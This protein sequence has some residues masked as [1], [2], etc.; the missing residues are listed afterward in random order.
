MRKKWFGVAF[1]AVLLFMATSGVYGKEDS[2]D[3]ELFVV[4]DTVVAY[5]PLDNRPI[6]TTR[7]SLLAESI[8]YTIMVPDEDLYATHLDNQSLNENGTQY[9]DGEKLIAWIQQMDAQGCDLFIISLDQILYGGLVNSRV[10]TD[11]RTLPIDPSED[12]SPDG[13]GDGGE[14][15]ESGD[16]ENGNQEGDENEGH[17]T[18]PAVIFD[19]EALAQNIEELKARYDR[20]Y[21]VLTADP[22]NRIF[23][24]DTVMRLATTV[25]Y[26]GYDEEIYGIYRAYAGVP[27]KILSDEELTVENIIAG[28]PYGQDGELA[29]NSMTDSDD[30]RLEFLQ[31]HDS[32]MIQT[33]L[34][35]RER[36]LRLSD[37]V[38]SKENNGQIHYFIGVDDSISHDS[39]QTN[40]REY[41]TQKLEGQGT[42]FEGTDELGIMALARLYTEER[43]VSVPIYLKYYG[44]GQ[45][46]ISDAYHADSLSGVVEKHIESLN[47]TIM[48]TTYNA[49]VHFYVLTSPLDSTKKEKYVEELIQD[50]QRNI[51]AHI[52]TIIVD[53]SGSDYGSLFYGRLIEETE[54]GF[55]LGYSS[56]NTWGN[57]V[58]IGLSQGLCRYIYLTGNFNRSEEAD[59]A[60]VQSLTFSFIKDIAYQKKTKSSLDSYYSR[61]LGLNVNNFYANRTKPLPNVVQTLLEEKMAVAAEPILENLL[62]SNFITNFSPYAEKQVSN[63]DLSDYRFP[64]SR[65]FEMNFDIDVGELEEPAE[66]VIH[67]PY[68]SG[69]PDG[70]FQPER[71]TSREEVAKMIAIASESELL[72]YQGAYDDVDE[73][74]WSASY[75]ETVTDLGCFQGYGGGIF[76]PESSMTRAEFAAFMVQ[77][78][79]AEGIELESSDATFSDV[80]ESD[81]FASAVDKV[82]GSGLVQGYPDQT[83]RPQQYVTRAE[84]VTMLNRLLGRDPETEELQDPGIFDLC[85][86]S[87][88]ETDHWAYLDIMEA[89]VEHSILVR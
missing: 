36:K 60:F 50:Y 83:F 28:Y 53:A 85:P 76:N 29:E 23:L 86:F 87:D 5:V 27:R 79:E 58:G 25:E 35:A 26:Y 72:E 49:K 69:Y 71:T 6:N 62:A 19:K 30:T 12:T 47:A 33:Y 9:G 61:V 66:T 42:L 43:N 7:V 70:R 65:T 46:S 3:A 74:R 80:A 18:E 32:F 13:E 84:A 20:L 4:N 73:S 31:D 37:Y 22:E 51:S 55:M 89:S 44:E 39:I 88:L 68:I 54:L 34:G 45:D 48:P 63:I 81:W 38:L 82:A 21:E 2:G 59:R 41:L 67:Q 24:F 15:N 1:A 56:W 64:W 77:Y 11:L 40:E 8:G 78:A 16:Y 52:P 10:V 17:D 14:D 57:A 75:I